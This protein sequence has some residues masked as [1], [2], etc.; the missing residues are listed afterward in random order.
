[1]GV[2]VPELI[3]LAVFVVP[4][5]V[6]A[7]FMVRLLRK[8]RLKAL[9]GGY[10]SLS[11]YMRAAPRTDAEKRDAVDLALMGLVF[12][13]LGL[14]FPPVLLV[15]LFPLFYGAR[16]IVYASMGLGLIDDARR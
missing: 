11:A 4:V 13:L 5:V 14:L 2:G 7:V 6:A 8:Q 9:G 16:K 10:A 3:I 15:G 12:C 1:V